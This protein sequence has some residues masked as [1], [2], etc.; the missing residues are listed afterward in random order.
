MKKVT[1]IILAGGKSSRMGEDKGLMS[2]YGKPMVEYVIDLAREISD[3]IIISSNNSNYK[4]FGFPVWKDR[5][6]DCGPLAGIHEGLKRSETENNFVISC[7]TPYV[8]PELYH[9]LEL[10]SEDCDVVVPI[11]EERIHPLLGIY[12]KS[13]LPVIEQH[14]NKGRFKIID[15]F[16][17]LEVNYVN[18]DKFETQIFRNINSKSDL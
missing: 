1:V 8:K 10:Q 12:K 17:K 7:D 6:K 13:C 3:E 14:L 2:L 18:A 4:K 5:Y 9:F 11:K 16:D 15:C